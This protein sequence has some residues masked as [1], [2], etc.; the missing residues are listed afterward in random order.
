MTATIP[1]NVGAGVC[2]N[3][4]IGGASNAN[5]AAGICARR[6]AKRRANAVTVT[7]IVITHHLFSLPRQENTYR[8]YQPATRRGEHPYG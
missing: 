7:A 8:Q 6:R 5:A 2:A 1:G 3:V 4:A